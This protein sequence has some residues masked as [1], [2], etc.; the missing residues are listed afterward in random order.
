MRHAGFARN[1]ESTLRLL[2]ER[3]HEVHVCFDGPFAHGADGGRPG[4]VER[5]ALERPRSVSFGPAPDRSGEP[6]FALGLRLRLGVD[7]LRFLAPSYAAAPKLRARAEER[8]GPL[9]RA[10]GRAVARRSGGPARLARLYRALDS[11]LPL[12]PGAR[13][14]VRRMRPDVVLVTPLVELGEPQT[15]FVRAAKALGVPTALCV[16]SWDNLTNKGSIPE[17][18]ELVAVWNEAQRTEAV[19]LHDVPAERVVATGAQP[20]DQWFEW[21]PSRDRASFAA[22]VGLPGEHPLVLY[23]CSSRFIAPEEAAFVRHWLAGLRGRPEREL[24][25]AEVLVRPHPQHAAQWSDVDLAGLG[26]VS[27]WPRAGADPVDAD[28]RRDYFDSIHFSSAVVGVNTSA[29]IETAI[30]GRPVLTQLAPEFRDTQG[31]TLHFAHLVEGGPLRVARSFGEHAAQLAEALAT[32]ATAP[33]P[34]AAV[35]GFLRSFVRPHGL[36]QP[37]TPRLVAAVEALAGTAPDLPRRPFGTPVVR[38]ALA[39]LAALAWVD[40]AARRRTRSV[41]ARALA[42]P[43]GASAARRWLVPLAASAEGDGPAA[44][45]ALR[46]LALEAQRVLAGARER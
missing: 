27:V 43:A 1:F 16:A 12:S 7:F 35:D 32:S 41:L 29:L 46:V 18:P 23:L 10:V 4:I 14:L 45:R 28:S 21:G 39:P 31:G 30:V 37:A 36:D 17:V 6:W 11:S 2:A 44:R 24:R 15:D 25:E 5:L 40:G 8:V 34:R 9:T 33:G 38:V 22:E 20:Y 42:T 13:E 26:P 19:E 3:G